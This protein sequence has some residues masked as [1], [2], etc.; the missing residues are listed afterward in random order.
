VSQAPGLYTKHQPLADLIASGYY[1]P[2]ADRDDVRQ[3]ARIALWEAARTWDRARGASFRTFARLIISRRLASAVRAANGGTARALTDA[4]RD[5]QLELLP[6]GTVADEVE[7][8][9]RFRGVVA[10]VAALP[11]QERVC[12]VHVASG[13][14]YRELSIPVKRVDNLVQQARGRLRGAA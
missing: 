4:S 14:A 6:G 3:E 8:R 1:L 5:T 12:L 11:E 13:G 9:E 10:A 7:A 2:G